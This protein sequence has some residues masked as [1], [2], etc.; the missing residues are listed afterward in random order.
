[1]KISIK[2]WRIGEARNLHRSLLLHYSDGVILFCNFKCL[3]TPYSS[4]L[5][6]GGSCIITQ[7]IGA[8][9][10]FKLP[11]RLDATGRLARAFQVIEV[12]I[13]S[14]YAGVTPLH[15]E[16]PGWPGLLESY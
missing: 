2:D 9:S 11:I 10:R 12:A 14:P 5:F 8:A 7:R 16:Q 3:A 1:M 15:D 6:A 4:S 13:K